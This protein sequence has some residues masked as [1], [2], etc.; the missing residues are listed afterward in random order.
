MRGAPAASLIVFAL[1]STSCSAV[2]NFNECS[3]DSDCALKA[4]GDLGYQPSDMYCTSDHFCVLGLP[5]DRL[6]S[7]A[8]GAPLD[9]NP[10][11][12]GG[13]FQLSGAATTNDAALANA[14]VLAIGEIFQ[15]HQQPIALILCD[16]AGP[17]Q[18]DGTTQAYRAL[19]KV[20]ETYHAVAVVGPTTSN[21]VTSSY[22]YAVANNVLMISPSATSPAI[23]N[24][25]K[26]GLVWRTAASD[27]LQAKVLA[28]RATTLL[29]AGANLDTAFANSQYGSLLNQSFIA[30][31]GGTPKQTIM[32]PDTMANVGMI[33]N[34]LATDSPGVA[35]L[36]ADSDAPALV[37]G[38]STARAGLSTTQFL[39]TDAAKGLDLIKMPDPA[40]LSRVSGTGPGIQSSNPV[41]IAFKG[42]YMNKFMADPAS[43]AF[44][45]NTYDAFYV[46]AMA[47]STVAKS[48]PGGNE[49]SAIVQKMSTKGSTSINVGPLAFAAGVTALQGGGAIDLNGTSGPLDF[50]PAG[51]GDVVTAPI[52]VWT[53]DTANPNSPFFV[54]ASVTVP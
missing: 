19:K 1:V 29:S 47:V 22:Q 39:M 50:D 9:Q 42:S 34:S 48:R 46:A 43:T 20:V 8:G 35:L 49:L 44:V 26:N 41:Y 45:A 5:E 37:Y 17:V 27:L 12:I 6:C 14:T 32:F 7:F 36:I 18:L 52:E 33:E 16:T 54:T 11:V 31:W 38:L 21:D 2:L 28:Q 51:S 3:K 4:P 24:F 53:I 30:A 40:V 23:T 10:A 25:V 13:L 15:F